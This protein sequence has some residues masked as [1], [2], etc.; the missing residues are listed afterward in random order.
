MSEVITQLNC[1]NCKTGFNTYISFGNPKES[2]DYKWG[3]EKCGHINTL[4]IQGW[5]S[6]I[7]Q[8]EVKV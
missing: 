6:P 1:E 8:R 2:F 5:I 4:H 3:C 7:K